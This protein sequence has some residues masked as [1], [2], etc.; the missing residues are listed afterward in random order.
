MAK[1]CH[2]EAAG[3]LLLWA[4]AAKSEQMSQLLNLLLKLP[5]ATRR[6]TVRAVTLK[7]PCV[8]KEYGEHRQ[9]AMP[10]SLGRVRDLLP[11]TFFGLPTFSSR[12]SS[13]R[14]SG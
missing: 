7:R 8:V 5:G 6:D 13:V 9:P 1:D 10:E 2:P 11:C 4:V 14:I 3:A 12:L